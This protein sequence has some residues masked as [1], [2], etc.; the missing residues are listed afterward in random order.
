MTLPPAKIFT[1]AKDPT[2]KGP[3]CIEINQSITSLNSAMGRKTTLTVEE[4]RAQQQAQ[5]RE[6]HQRRRLDPEKL[7]QK[8]E[9]DRLRQRERYQQA[10]LTAH[11]PLALLA[12]TAT[13]AQLLEE[14]EEHDGAEFSGEISTSV[15]IP[16]CMEVGTG[17]FED[18]CMLIESH[19]NEEGQSLIHNCADSRKPHR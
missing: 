8:K 13:Q 7:A 19:S 17:S 11:D 1:I 5:W 4:K 18:E 3:T 9:R 6:H 16:E 15:P 2:H 14:L 12:D 10:K